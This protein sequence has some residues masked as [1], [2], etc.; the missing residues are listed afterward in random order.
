[1]RHL[2]GGKIRKIVLGQRLQRKA[3]A[4][5]LDRQ[6]RA[7]AVAF[8]H[9]LRP[10]RQF[11]HDVVK[12]MRRNGRGTGGRGFSRQRLGDFEIEVGGFQRQPRVLGPDQHVAEDRNG[13]APLDH[14]VHVA[15]RF[16]ELRAFDG[17]LHCHTRLIRRG[18][19]RAAPKAHRG[20][21]TRKADRSW[22]RPVRPGGPQSGADGGQAQE[23]PLAVPHFWDFAGLLF[24]HPILAARPAL[25]ARGGQGVFKGY[26]LCN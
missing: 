19:S 7:V 6:H 25:P 2:A 5:G 1:M 13:V 14:A 15:Q 26:S 16:Q 12:H 24:Q 21:W 8:Q 4:A 23:M 10:V 17:N 3:R 9:D 18:K 11:A 22:I 20:V